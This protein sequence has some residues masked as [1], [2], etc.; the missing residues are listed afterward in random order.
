MSATMWRGAVCVALATLAA[1]CGSSWRIKSGAAPAQPATATACFEKIKSLAGEWEMAPSKEGDEPMKVTYRVTSGGTAVMETLMP[2]KPHEMVTM[3]HLDNGRL[4]LTHYCS[5][6]NQPMMVLQP[7]ADSS[8]MSFAHCGGTGIA[9]PDAPHMA[10]LDMTILDAEHLNCLWGMS[11]KGK[12][13][14]HQAFA[15]V[16][17]S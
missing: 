3:Y 13:E 1:G 11:K 16:R 8:H 10:S 9:S 5:M 12:L 7:G 2:G 6:G 17:K 15:F 4:V 14:K